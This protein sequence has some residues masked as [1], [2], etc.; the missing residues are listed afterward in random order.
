MMT[1]VQTCPLFQ[2][3]RLTFNRLLLGSSIELRDDILERRG[4]WILD[5]QISG[6]LKIAKINQ[7]CSD[8]HR[9][10]GLYAGNRFVRYHCIAS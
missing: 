1:I 6:D 2:T 4:V 7:I 3:D 9:H 8:K 10:S 5:S